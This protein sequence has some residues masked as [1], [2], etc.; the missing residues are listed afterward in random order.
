MP[1]PTCQEGRRG[2]SS[3]GCTTDTIPSTKC[4]VERLM[5]TPGLA[6]PKFRVHM[7]YGEVWGLGSSISQSRLLEP[8]LIPV[9]SAL[10]CECATKE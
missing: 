1:R 3:C 9:G 6:T 5:A 7:Q 8:A 4:G 2:K 10:S